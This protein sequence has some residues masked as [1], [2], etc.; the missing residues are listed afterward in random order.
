MILVY[1]ILKNETRQK[2]RNL[3][4]NE[5][6]PRIDS[7]N[8]E[9]SQLLNGFAKFF[10]NFSVAFNNHVPRTCRMH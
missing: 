5:N 6:V 9:S 10:L 4:L 2:Q 1:S 8:E 7:E 3:F